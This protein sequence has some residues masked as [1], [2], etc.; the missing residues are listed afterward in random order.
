M[1]I[2]DTKNFF[3]HNERIAT[4][5]RTNTICSICILC[6][7]KTSTVDPQTTEMLARTIYTMHCVLWA[8][9]K[10]MAYSNSIQFAK[11]ANNLEHHLARCYLGHSKRMTMAIR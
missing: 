11:N 4:E 8:A 10:R 3:P 6:F 7:K 2:N 1:E 9:A 5:S